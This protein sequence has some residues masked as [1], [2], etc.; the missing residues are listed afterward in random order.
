MNNGK[1][2]VD[3]CRILLLKIIEQAVR[4]F[5]CLDTA[6][7]Q[8][9]QYDYETACQFLFDDNYYI[10]FGGQDRSLS[11]IV[12]ILDIDLIWLRRKIVQKKDQKVRKQG[13][14][15]CTIQ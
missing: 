5:L 14:N 6:L 2:Y 8:T 1:P 4:D 13:E 3:E 12:D 7:S 11:E 15:G 9:D 10:N